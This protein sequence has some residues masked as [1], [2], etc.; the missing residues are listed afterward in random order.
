[1]DNPAHQTFNFIFEGNGNCLRPQKKPTKKK[2]DKVFML[3]GASHRSSLASK[4]QKSA[5]I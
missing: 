5:A 3:V 4:E 2:V 1:M